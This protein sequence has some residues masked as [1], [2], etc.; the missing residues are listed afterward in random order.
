[1]LNRKEL[2]GFSFLFR[3]GECYTQSCNGG[4]EEAG[5]ASPLGDLCVFLFMYSSLLYDSCLAIV[6]QETETDPVKC[7]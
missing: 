5:D 7:S 3:R 2:G 1:M 4:K 6:S